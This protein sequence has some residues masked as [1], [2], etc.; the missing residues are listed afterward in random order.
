MNPPDQFDVYA[1][2]LAGFA[3]AFISLKFIQGSWPERIVMAIGGSFFSFYASPW[4]ASKTGLPE[5][6]SGFLLGLFGMAICAKVWEWIQ[7]APV[8]GIWG[9]LLEWF[10]RKKGGE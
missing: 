5:G 6:L 7:Q 10:P 9:A 1:T 8:S 4:A 3:G 2:K